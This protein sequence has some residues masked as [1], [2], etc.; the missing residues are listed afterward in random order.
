MLSAHKHESICIC[1][2]VCML[3]NAAC[4]YI[5]TNRCM[6]ASPYLCRQ[7]SMNIYVCVYIQTCISMYICLHNILFFVHYNDISITNYNN[8]SI[9]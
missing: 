1:M 7:I 3:V 2:F 8:G 5:L 9:I 6:N 4:I